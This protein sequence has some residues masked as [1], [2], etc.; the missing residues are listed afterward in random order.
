[1]KL[2]YPP[3]PKKSHLYIKKKIPLN[4]CFMKYKFKSQ[5]PSLGP[6][7]TQGVIFHCPLLSG[8][9]K[10]PRFKN[11]GIGGDGESDDLVQKGTVEKRRNQK[12]GV[13]L[14]RVL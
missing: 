8:D 5:A 3:P 13:V 7:G 14:V 2:L 6:I 1:M 10:P 4:C 12:C 9:L 11:S